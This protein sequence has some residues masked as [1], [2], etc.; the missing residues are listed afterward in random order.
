MIDFVYLLY[1]CIIFKPRHVDI[2]D[3]V[4]LRN[5]RQVTHLPP[6]WDFFY[7]PWHRHQTEGISVSSEKR[8][9]SWVKEIAKVSKQ[10]QWESDPLPLDWQS[11]ALTAE[12]IICPPEYAWYWLLLYC[13]SFILLSQVYTFAM[14]THFCSLRHMPS[15]NKALYLSC[16]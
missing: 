1:L 13:I 7:F 6:V 11:C 9:Q 14:A 5:P 16:V 10:P 3:Q 8:W 2:I 15:D 12:P 4:E